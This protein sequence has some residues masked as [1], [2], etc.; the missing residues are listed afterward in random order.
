MPL[1]CR[2]ISIRKKWICG[3]W[4]WWLS[5]CQHSVFFPVLLFTCT[6]WYANHLISYKT[7]YPGRKWG[8]TWRKAGIWDQGIWWLDARSGA[9]EGTNQKSDWWCCGKRKNIQRTEYEKLLYQINPHF[10]LNT[11]NS[12]QWMARMSKQNNIMEFVQRLKR[13]LSY[14]LGK[15]ECRRHFEQKSILWKII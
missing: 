10:L 13:L 6:G 14:N 2:K 8:I 12:V 1:H 5:F 4:S 7:D 3:D 11:L 9:D 15:R